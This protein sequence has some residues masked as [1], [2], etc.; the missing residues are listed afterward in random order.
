MLRY[1][2]IP[3]VLFTLSN[4]HFRRIILL[5]KF[6]NYPRNCTRVMIRAILISRFSDS[7]WIKIKKSVTKIPLMQRPGTQ[8][9]WPCLCPQCYGQHF[10]SLA[11]KP[12]CRFQYWTHWN[13]RRIPNPVRQQDRTALST[14]LHRNT[15]WLTPTVSN[16]VSVQVRSDHDIELL[17]LGYQ[18][19]CAI[20]DD[21]VVIF[22]AGIIFWH[23]C[24]DLAE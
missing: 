17:W 20:V 15:E 12:P 18:L 19:H 8:S 11:R 21:N 10:W 9:D 13:C 23:F 14:F 2:K 16:N 1:S 3:L 6:T 4:V 7:F 24:A 22:N 5:A